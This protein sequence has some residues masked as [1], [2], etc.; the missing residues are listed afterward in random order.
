[1]SWRMRR[2]GGSGG[3]K[4]VRGRMKR[5]GGRGEVEDIGV[6]GRKRRCTSVTYFNFPN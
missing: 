4:A 2:G 5:K 1:M 3:E 6:R